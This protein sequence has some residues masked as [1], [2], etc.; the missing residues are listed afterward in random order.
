MG[1]NASDRNILIVNRIPRTDDSNR[2]C[3]LVD[4][5]KANH[6]GCDTNPGELRMRDAISTEVVCPPDTG[7]QKTG[8]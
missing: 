3:G 8:L 1:V 5:A 2:C 6:V 4:S 7:N